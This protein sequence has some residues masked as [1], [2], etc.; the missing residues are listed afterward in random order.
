MSRQPMC[1]SCWHS[2]IVCCLICRHCK[3]L[4][5]R[6]SILRENAQASRERLEAAEKRD[7]EKREAAAAKNDLEAFIIAMRGA[8]EGGETLAQARLLPRD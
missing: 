2:A 5:G 7:A 8:L 3:H 4:L 6:Q 1:A